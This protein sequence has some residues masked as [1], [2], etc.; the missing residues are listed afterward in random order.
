M[1]R[2]LQ[3]LAFA[4]SI[5]LIC[6]HLPAADGVPLSRQEAEQLTL[7]NH[8][9]ITAADLLALAS[10]QVVRET[11]SARFP[12]ITA[13]VTAVGTSGD[14]TRIAAGALNNPLILER[15]AEGINL[16]QT[17]TDFGRTANLVSSSKL[18]S[19]AE[20]QNA[21]AT[22]EQILRQVDTVYFETLQA[23]SVVAVADQT[24]ATRQS[25]FEQAN[26]M[27]SNGLRS[28]LDASLA[29][30]SLEEGKLFQAD[31]GN[32]LQASFARLAALLGE[33]K[34]R[35]YQLAD[36][37]PPTN[38][39]A[40]DADQLVQEALRNR[41]DL[42][43]LRFEHD[44][45]TKFARA[46]HELHYPTISAVGSGGLIQNHDRQLKANYA[47]AGVNLS[48]PIFDGLL[49]SAREKE[50]DLRARAA[51]EKLREV[52]ND[53]ISDVRVAALNYSNALERL[54]LTGKLLD[55]ANE[56]FDLAQ[57]RYRAGSSS[58]VELGQAQ[59]SKTEAEIALARA[60]YD[61][62]MRIADLSYQTGR[63]R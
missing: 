48:L 50:A 53:V 34:I 4:A 41:P 52:E 42:V 32:E 2:T 38:M 61:L 51:D 49:F 56:A 6:P 24:V 44:A 9:G 27:A 5:A 30:V 60:K 22:R 19:Q 26:L 1:T 36:E 54:D 59:L 43:R 55:S 35:N 28:G 13:N 62:Q 7:R 10:K 57:A 16:S 18:H 47:A 17:I 20:A 33:R 25:I 40:P 12:T 21:L 15:N 31:A 58:F 46:E 39:P 14:N 23:Q 45:A 8:P 11:R 37:P 63:L 29:Q 3:S